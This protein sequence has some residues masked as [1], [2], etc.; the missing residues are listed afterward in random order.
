MITIV[1]DQ[2]FFVALNSVRI[3]STHHELDFFFPLQSITHSD[4]EIT[5]RPGTS[6][7]CAA[8]SMRW[9]HL[10]SYWKPYDY[11]ASKSHGKQS[12]RHGYVGYSARHRAHALHYPIQL[13]HPRKPVGTL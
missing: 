6:T 11:V 13:H 3:V 5:D 2:S 12:A 1:Q 7:A 4:D 8:G 10:Q 9:P